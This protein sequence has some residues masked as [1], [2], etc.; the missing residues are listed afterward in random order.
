MKSNVYFTDLR[1]KS[2]ESLLDKTARLFDLVGFGGLLRPGD[3]VAVKLHWGE[4]GNVA[5]LPP[6][7]ARRLV[8]KVRE[9]GGKPF[10]TDTNTLYTGGRHNA[11]DHI[12]T[13]LKNG[14]S[15]ASAGAPIIIA[16]GLSGGDSVEVPADG[17]RVP[18]V[19]VAGAIYCADA[20]LS[21]AHFKGH[22]LFGFGGA[23]K[24]IAMGCTTPAGKQILHS[25]VKPKVDRGRCIA[26]GR[27]VRSCAHGAIRLA[28][29]GKAGID[30]DRCVGCGE[31]V[32]VCPAEA[33][34]V[35]WE[36]A[37]EPLLEKSAEY[38]KAI[39]ANKGGRAAF[40]NFLLRMSP[41][42]DCYE[43]NDAP[44]VADIGIV[45]SRD[46]V[47]IDQASTDLVNAGQVLSSSRLK[48]KNPDGDAITAATGVKGWRRILEYAEEIGVGTRSYELVRIGGK[49]T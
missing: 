10:L 46:P 39:L 14:F 30:T 18:S 2:G 34:P 21:L 20:I 49:R 22:E 5:F 29:G 45:A 35:N 28:E 13:A 31:C 25:D 1:A 19:R 8:E 27:C 47:A 37:A 4:W 43:W 44:F 38:V 7:F 15:V 32:A 23:L 6:P 33:I 42:C 48:G 26:C 41:E 24:N 40:L 11:I 12:L 17:K 3:K 36:T 9:A 16:D